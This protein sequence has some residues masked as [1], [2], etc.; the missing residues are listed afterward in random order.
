MKRLRITA[1]DED[2]RGDDAPRVAFVQLLH[3]RAARC[4]TCGKVFMGPLAPT[5]AQGTRHERVFAKDGCLSYPPLW[6]R[7]I[8]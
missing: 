5:I 8:R 2:A 4:S 1:F 3:L 6:V 7:V